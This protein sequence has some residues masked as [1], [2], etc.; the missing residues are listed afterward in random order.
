[1][2]QKHILKIKSEDRLFE[3]IPKKIKENGRVRYAKS[4]V[5]NCDISKKDISK[6]QGYIE[7]Q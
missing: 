6:K 7:V 2:R 1:M 3:K 5:V 4:V